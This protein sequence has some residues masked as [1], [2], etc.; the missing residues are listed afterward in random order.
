[1]FE[2]IA[3]PVL[4]QVYDLQ[5]QAGAR[6]KLAERKEEAE[7]RRISERKEEN[8]NEKEKTKSKMNSR[9]RKLVNEHRV[10]SVA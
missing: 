2:V 1:M 6:R 8:V 3:Q 10:H 9:G 5:L 4:R 7:R